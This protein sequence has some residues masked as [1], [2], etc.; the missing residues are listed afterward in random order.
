M[1][2]IEL[3]GLMQILL[4]HGKGLPRGPK[5]QIQVYPEGAVLTKE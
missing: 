1:L 5:D 3:D 4:P 2:W